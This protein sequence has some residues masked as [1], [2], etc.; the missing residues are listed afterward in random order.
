AAAEIRAADRV[1]GNPYR[2]V[3][4]GRWARLDRDAPEAV[5]LALEGRV[6][7]GP[8][9]AEDLDPLDHPGHPIAPLQAVEEP[10]DTPAL[11]RNDSRAHHEH[12]AAL[13]DDVQAGPLVG[14]EHRIT[15]RKGSHAR[16]AEADALRPTGDC[17]QQ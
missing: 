8:Q 15:Q 17:G 2:R 6:R 14:Q 12:G 1:V 7:L 16:G 10:L 11:L 4:F 5:M 13:G 3:W 9:Q